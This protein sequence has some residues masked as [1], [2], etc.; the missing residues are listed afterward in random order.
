MCNNFIALFLKAW[1]NC[2]LVI[3]Y[4]AQTSLRWVHGVITLPVAAV[5]TSSNQHDGS[6]LVLSAVTEHPQS[7]NTYAI[8]RQQWRRGWWR[9][10]GCSVTGV[11][12][13][14]SSGAR[15]QHC[16]AHCTDALYCAVVISPSDPDVC[17]TT[18]VFAVQCDS[19]AA[20]TSSWS[21]SL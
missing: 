5:P 19:K 18:L 11:N 2:A 4:Y 12:W 13:T 9:A 10:E 17:R 21:H 14:D 7:V 8:Q 20:V 16:V 15:M 6:C 1:R 3:S